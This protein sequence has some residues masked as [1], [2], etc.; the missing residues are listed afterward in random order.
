[1]AGV[2]PVARFSHDAGC[3]SVGNQDFAGTAIEPH[4]SAGLQVGVKQGIGEGLGAPFYVKGL[5]LDIGP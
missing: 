2:D 3:M 5:E 1:M 4:L